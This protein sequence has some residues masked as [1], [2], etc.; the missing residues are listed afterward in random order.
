MPN[1]RPSGLI[2]RVCRIPFVFKAGGATLAYDA[3]GNLT[4]DGTVT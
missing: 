3:N 1:V 2:A 4:S